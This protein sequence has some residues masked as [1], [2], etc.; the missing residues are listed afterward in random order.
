MPLI[1]IDTQD[2]PELLMQLHHFCELT[3]CQ[4]FGDNIGEHPQIRNP[5]IKYVWLTGNAPDLFKPILL[6]MAL[7]GTKHEWNKQ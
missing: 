4:M 5:S 2:D 6:E 7:K 3:G 1:K